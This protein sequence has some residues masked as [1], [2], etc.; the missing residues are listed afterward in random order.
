MERIDQVDQRHLPLAWP[1]LEELPEF[2]GEI[3]RSNLDNLERL[4]L[5]TWHSDGPVNVPLPDDP[6]ERSSEV[7][8]LVTSFGREFLKVCSVAPL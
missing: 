5:I 8:V 1:V 7:R 4:G 3:R 2:A 6:Y